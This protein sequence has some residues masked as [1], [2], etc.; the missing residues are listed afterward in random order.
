MVILECVIVALPTSWCWAD[1]PDGPGKP[2]SCIWGIFLALSEADL[3][4]A[5]VI[6]HFGD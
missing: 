3:S 5:W 1:G 6:V 2:A 4:H